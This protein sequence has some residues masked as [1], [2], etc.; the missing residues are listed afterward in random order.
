MPSSG[1][2]ACSPGPCSGLVSTAD[3]DTHHGAVD[4]VAN[5]VSLLTMA[6]VGSTSRDKACPPATARAASGMCLHRLAFSTCCWGAMY[7]NA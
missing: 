6:V 1:K 4:T 2:V 3:D 7:R 5:A